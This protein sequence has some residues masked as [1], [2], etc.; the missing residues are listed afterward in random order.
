MASVGLKS[1]NVAD[2][3]AVYWTTAWLGTRGRSDDLPKSQMIA[4]RNQAASALSAT[5]LFAKATN[6]QKQEMAEAMILQA[7]LISA[8][9]DSAKSDATLMNQVKV[10]ITQGAKGIGINLDKMTLTANGF[11]PSGE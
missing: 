8:F 5:S 6:V 7:V 4:V 2:A 9:V 1:N 11:V 10:A 3:Y